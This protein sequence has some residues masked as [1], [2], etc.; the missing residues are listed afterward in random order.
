MITSLQPDTIVGAM[1][2]REQAR[3]VTQV[4]PNARQNQVTGFQDGVLHVRIAA[5]PIKGQA[6]QELVKFLSDILHTSKSNITIEKGATSR[7]K[8][9]AIQGL[10]EKQVIR[11]LEELF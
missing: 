7:K 1:V 8:T 6:N 2:E 9:V 3:I 4:R 10:S 11:L 5:P